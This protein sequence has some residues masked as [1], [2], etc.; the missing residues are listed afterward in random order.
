[1]QNATESCGVI[2][3]PATC[4]TRDEQERLGMFSEFLGVDRDLAPSGIDRVL[5]D[6]EG[7]EDR[8]LFDFADQ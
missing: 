2:P 1:M 5:A 7:E 8:E 4:L 6:L 3:G